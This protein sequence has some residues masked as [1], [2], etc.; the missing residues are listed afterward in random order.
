MFRPHYAICTCHGLKRLIVVRAGLCKIGNDEKKKNSNKSKAG[1]VERGKVN[2]NTKPG[3]V[4]KGL[5]GNGSSNNVQPSA[6]GK[7]FYVGRSHKHWINR[8]RK[9]TGELDLFRKL[10]EERGPYSQISGQWVDFHPAIFSH[11]LGKGAYGR[12]R[13][14]EKNI[15]IKTIEEHTMWGEQRHKLKNLPKWAWIFELEKELKEE[16]YKTYR[17]TLNQ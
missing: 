4:H 6:S 5:A 17:K 13:L 14:Y 9:R 1:S 2:G 3:K 10:Y 16:Y 11:I 12:F 7:R 8:K 15:V